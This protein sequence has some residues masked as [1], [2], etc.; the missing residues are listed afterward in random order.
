MQTKAEICEGLTTT[1]NLVATEIAAISNHDFTAKPHPETW[2]IAEEFDHILKANS[3]VSSAL[4][5]KPFLLKW[6]FGKPNRAL[7]SYTEV[8]DRY[9]QKL[10]DIK[11][12]PAPAAFRSKEGQE[13][14]KSNMLSHWNSTTN[15]LNLRITKWSD[16][17]LN[18]TLLPHP[19]LG[20]MMVREILFFTNFHTLHHLQS[21]QRKLASLN[22]AS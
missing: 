15:K 18:R 5:R 13:F 11:G 4:K 14:H 1:L 20:K 10:V 12:V 16:R 6:K 21:I 2:S 3:T 22:Q 17:N 7:R 9:N 8:Q 19:L